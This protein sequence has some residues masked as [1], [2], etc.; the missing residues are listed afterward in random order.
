VQI[1]PFTLHRDPRWYDAPD[2]YRPAR[3]REPTTWPQFAYLP[4]GAGPR[5]RI[6]QNFALM[7]ACLVAATI[8]QSWQP[9]QLASLPSASA[10]FSLRPSGGLP[11]VWCSRTQP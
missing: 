2:V 3:F 1:V 10:K 9:A 4:F 11:M 8:L 7:E 6:G 5:G